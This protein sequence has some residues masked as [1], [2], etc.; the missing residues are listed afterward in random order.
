MNEILQIKLPTWGGDDW[1]AWNL[2]KSGFFTVNTVWMYN[3]S[4]VPT[5]LDLARDR[6]V[7]GLR[8]RNFGLSM[9]PRK[10]VFLLGI[11]RNGLPPKANGHWRHLADH[12]SCNLCGAEI[13]DVFHVVLACP[14]ARAL[15]EATH[16]HWVLPLEEHMVFTGPDLVAAALR[17]V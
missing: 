16:D 7:I 12:S 13:E 9:F 4:L 11:V 17:E 15:R 10:Y 1:I 6:T 2:E 3:W 8:G 14:H 5:R